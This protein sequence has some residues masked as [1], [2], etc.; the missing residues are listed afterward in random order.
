MKPTAD[1][2][3]QYQAMFDHFNAALF[4]GKLPPVFLNFSRDKKAALGYFVPQR[5]G[6]D[7]TQVAEITLNPDHLL[8]RGARDTASTLV[9]EMVHLWQ[10]AFGKSSRPGYHNAEWAM[11][12]EEI[13]LMPSSTGEPGGRRVGQQMTHYIIDNGAFARTFTEIA[14]TLPWHSDSRVE[15]AKKYDKTKRKYTCPTC[16]ASVWGKPNLKLGCL[17]CNTVLA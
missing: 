1:Q 3:N 13:G 15:A 2:F 11:K 6:R 9:H 7:A 10:H 12:M 5:W 16:G 17:A 14:H 4:G 8:R